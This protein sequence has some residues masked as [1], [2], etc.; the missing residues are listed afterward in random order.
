MAKKTDIYGI[1]NILGQASLDPLRTIKGN[2][3]SDILVEKI[4]KKSQNI[5]LL[6]NINLGGVFLQPQWM[7]MMI[8][9]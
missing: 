1:I 9:R 3:I 5:V 7:T 4:I 8:L 2:T 6:N